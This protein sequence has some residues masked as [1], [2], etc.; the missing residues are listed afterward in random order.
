[1][2]EAILTEDGRALLNPDLPV[3]PELRAALL[4]A[5]H[6]K[7]SS[8]A[9]AKADAVQSL[10]ALP[11]KQQQRDEVVILLAE[12]G[13]SHDAFKLAARLVKHSYHGPSLLWYKSTR[14]I[15]NDPGF[16]ALVRELGLID[17]WKATHTRPDACGENAPPFFCQLISRQCPQGVASGHSPAAAKAC[18]E[19]GPVW[20][21]PDMDCR[22]MRLPHLQPVGRARSSTAAPLKDRK[23]HF[24]ACS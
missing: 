10:L 19:P 8:D 21:N 14:G 1:M 18:P 20:S 6:A 4:K 7:S 5:Y 9:N 24:I 2:H 22:K 17:Y 15:L 11:E 23:W 13:A 16:P 3:S 12:L